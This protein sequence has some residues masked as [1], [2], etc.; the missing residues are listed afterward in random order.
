MGSS[1]PSE[2]PII[3]STGYSSK[4]DTFVPSKTCDGP[5]LHS[6]LLRVKTSILS[7][8]YHSRSDPNVTLDHFGEDFVRE[9][10]SGKLNWYNSYRNVDFRKSHTLIHKTYNLKGSKTKERE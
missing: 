10:R 1:L 9:R 7:T 3:N 6:L 2:D 8:L 4:K 5:F